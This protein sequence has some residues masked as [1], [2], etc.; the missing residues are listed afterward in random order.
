L[1]KGSLSLFANTRDRGVVDLGYVEVHDAP[2]RLPN[3]AARGGFGTFG[4]ADGLAMAKLDDFRYAVELH[5]KQVVFNLYR[6]ELDPP[7]K[8]KLLP[9]EIYVGPSFDESGLQFYL[10]YDSAQSHAFWVLNEDVRV[11][12][13][14]SSRV[15]DVLIGKRTGFAFYEDKERKRK[16]LIGAKAEN[17][18]QNNWYDGP[19]DQM[20]D[21]LVSTG[22]L[23]VQSYL[24]RSY[25]G[26][27]ARIDK[28]G[29]YLDC[30]GARV[31]VA[32]YLVYFSERDVLERAAACAKAPSLSV[33]HACLTEQRFE[34]PPGYFEGSVEVASDAGWSAVAGTS[35]TLGPSN[36][37]TP[38]SGPTIEIR[39]PSE[40]P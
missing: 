40:S 28:Y 7:R 38:A 17:V 1:F 24:E 19:F 33:R 16:I 30:E 21:N 13:T 12:E 8:A 32:P 36:L 39:S 31:A 23:E 27:R 6:P 26:T 11:A 18:L 9:D 29:N 37:F 15:S 35:M 25:P 5:G 3:P 10:F 14:F 4:A 2:R 20:P 34:V 22:Q